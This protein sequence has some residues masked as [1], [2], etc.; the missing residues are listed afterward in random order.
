MYYINIMPLYKTLFQKFFYKI[1][2]NLKKKHDKIVK[3]IFVGDHFYGN[4]NY[5]NPQCVYA[6]K[7]WKEFYNLC[8]VTL[9]ETKQNKHKNK[10]FRF[11]QNKWNSLMLSKMYA[12]NLNLMLKMNLLNDILL[13][14]NN[15]I[16]LTG[17]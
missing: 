16:R 2:R 12:N 10:A 7:F 15:C 11:F 3:I 14:W 6:A 5:S 13:Y 1:T 17:S 9:F 8:Q 4:K